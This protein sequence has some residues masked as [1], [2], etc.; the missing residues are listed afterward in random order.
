MIMH[1]LKQYLNSIAMEKQ[2]CIWRYF[3]VLKI[4]WTC[5]FTTNTYVGVGTFFF[6]G[7]QKSNDYITIYFMTAKL[8][9]T[10]IGCIH[11]KISLVTNAPEFICMTESTKSICPGDLCWSFEWAMR[12][13]SLRVYLLGVKQPC[14]VTIPY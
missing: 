3:I 12:L 9:E 6:C 1:Y 11:I 13:W 14:R 10:H 2:T 7:E 8:N 4:M 5:F